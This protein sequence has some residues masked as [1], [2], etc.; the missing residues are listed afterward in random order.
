ML[1]SN[2]SEQLR[3]RLAETGSFY[4]I[5]LIWNRLAAKTNTPQSVRFQLIEHLDSTSLDLNVLGQVMSYEEFTVFGANRLPG[6]AHRARNPEYY[7]F[8]GKECDEESGLLLLCR[9]ASSSVARPVGIL[10]PGRVAER[11][12]LIRPSEQ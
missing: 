12:Q 6:R 3:G 5:C 1:F 11:A 7:H 8:M 2:W 9:A 4:H 10:R